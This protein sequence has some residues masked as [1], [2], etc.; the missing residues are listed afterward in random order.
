MDECCVNGVVW[1]RICESGNKALP[2][3][4]LAIPFLHVCIV[5]L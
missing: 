1:L 5:R 3:R 2:A 4:M